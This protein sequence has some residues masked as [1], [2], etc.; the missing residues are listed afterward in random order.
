VEKRG[1]QRLGGGRGEEGVAWGGRGREG[2]ESE[3]GG[4][5]GK[6]GGVEWGEKGG[7]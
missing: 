1:G 6:G 5:A 7:K 2:E 4:Q 3:K